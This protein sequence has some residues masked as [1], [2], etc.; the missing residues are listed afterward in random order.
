MFA[1][2]LCGGMTAPSSLQE[3]LMACMHCLNAQFYCRLR[4][5]GEQ[6]TA[7]SNSGLCLTLRCPI[8]PSGLLTPQGPCNLKALCPGSELH[9]QMGSFSGSAAP[10]LGD[11]EV[12]ESEE[13]RLGGPHPSEWGRN[14][15][16]LAEDPFT[17]RSSGSTQYL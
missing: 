7:C 5:A 6:V 15:W 17:I 16:V 4:M 14:S 13:R 1:L 3:N 2:S 9:Q 8:A 12:E 11:S 10:H